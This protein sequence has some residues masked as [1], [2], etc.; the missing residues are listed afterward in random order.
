MLVYLSILFLML[1]LL[2]VFI[3]TKQGLMEDHQIGDMCHP[4]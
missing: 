4:V 1:F 3:I 2:F